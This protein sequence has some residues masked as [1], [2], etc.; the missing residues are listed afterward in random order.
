M[1]KALLTLLLVLLH[2]SAIPNNYSSYSFLHITGDNGLSQSHVK[3]ILKDSYGF[4]W[5]GTKNGLNR[6]DG[7][8]ILQLDC[9]DY[10][11]KKGNHNISALFEDK[12]KKLWVG[13]DRG[14][15]LYD[16]MLD[17]FTA[18]DDKAE[19]GASLDNWVSNIVADSVGNIWVVIPDQGVF[20]YAG[21]KLYFY[22][23]IDRNNFK[24]ETPD[25]IHVTSK[26][27]V[28]VGTWGAGLFRYDTAKDKFEQYKADKDNNS[29]TALSI[30]SICE[31]DGWLIMAIQNGRIMKYHPRQNILRSLDLA[32]VSHTFVRNVSMHGDE[33]WAGTHE[34][35]YIINEK[36]GTVVHLKS[37]LIEP[38]SL[39]DNIIYTMYEDDEGGMWLGTMFGGV[40]Y[41][42]NRGLIFEKY[43][44]LNTGQ[45]LSSKRI[46]ELVEDKKGN[47]WI[48]TE[49]GGVN[50]L[51]RSGQITRM[52]SNDKE[53]RN[54]TI[55]NM[56]IY[57]EN[58]YCGLFKEGLDVIKPTGE[59]V[60]YSDKALNIEEGS[61]WAFC[62]DKKG[63]KWIGTG[64]GLFM[65]D[66]DSFLF[67]KVNEVG[68]DWIFDIFEDREGNL[69]FA[70]MGS[71][72]WKHN[73]QANSFEKYINKEGEP[74]SLSSN[75]VSSVMQDSKGR[76]WLS[77]DRGG[78][79]RYNAETNDFT[80]FSIKEG[81]PDDVAY[82]ILEDDAHNLWFGTNKGLVKFNPETK[83]IHVFTTKDG[84]LGNQFNYKSALKVGDGR[85]FFGGINGLIAFDPN[86]S[87]QQLAPP[88]PIYISK[89]SIYNKEIT[90]HTP[91]SP[92]KKNIVGTEEI[93]LPYNQSNIS[94]DIALLSYST[95]KS[96]QY[97]YRLDPL[98]KDW[99]KAISNQNI[100]YA[101]LSPGKY[102]F[103][104][105]ADNSN[106]QLAKRSLSIVILP[107]WWLS[108]WAYSCYVF[109][110]ISSIWACFF[111]YKRRKE[112]QMTESQKLFEIQKEKELYESKVEFFT[113]IAH[114]IRTPLTLI[115]SPLENV[116]SS[117]SVSD[118]IRDDLEIMD[119]NTNR[120]LDLVNQLL[121]FRKT[122]TQ[123]FQLNFVECDVSDILQ[124]T[125]KRFRL[126]A[127][128][129]ELEFVI[130][131]PETVYASVD[132]E[133]L[134]K[135]ISNLLSNAIKY[136]ETYIRVRLYVEEDKLLFS[137]CNDGPVVP[138]KMREE[139]FKPFIQYK[140][141]VLSSVS[142]TGIG[143]ALARLL[144]ELHEG[145]L[146]MEDSMECNCFLLSL[147]LKHV[148]TVTIE[149]KEPVMNEESSGEGEPETGRKQC[150][151]TLLVVEDSLEMRL[152]V[153]KQLSSEY[154][155]LT[156]VN[157]IEALKVL[158]EHTVNLVISDIMMPEMDGLELCEHLK[159]ELDYSHI[160]IILLTAKTTLQAKIEGMRL[161]ADVYIEKP[162]SVEYL[163]VC[164]SNL[165]SNREKLRVSFAH[166]P[167]VQ[168]NSMA[169][170]KADETFLKT[171]KEVVVANM[172]N[173]EFCLD[174]MA[175]LL[176]MSRSSLN[177]KIKGIL[178]L[179]PN[180][181]IRLERL[182]KAAQ[183]LQEGECKINEV[184]Y[185]TGFNTPSYF[186]KCFQ[187]QFGVLPK[188]FIK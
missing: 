9:D 79:C 114:E 26:G 118:E 119:L 40:N 32:D 142:G 47:V 39:S 53:Q 43:V 127:R 107:P 31:S 126:S 90:V 6:Y 4:M 74:N 140:E 33:I 83:D 46:R 159:S 11:A 137:V 52:K 88:S 178:D 164:V 141:G 3:A 155:V 101:K 29:L 95:T 58:I 96:N 1:K 20:R 30:N 67:S 170:T 81:L 64:S 177:R 109:F 56:S 35:V 36:K 173:P 62:I 8:S 34:G 75:S 117:K 116:L 156:A 110:F 179:T 70:S 186:T 99:V 136:S 149:R 84:L 133:G 54:R 24:K 61:V 169:M 80:S 153:T 187:K 59:V 108:V 87:R 55:L 97:Y 161:G 98:D 130:D 129:K 38:F 145:A 104:I 106:S 168:A 100:S 41:L 172:Q 132:K 128:Q 121:D 13:T 115:K 42:P 112:R 10:V 185:M 50:I 71:G 151:Y 182:K 23:I 122:E 146:Y 163:R 180:D 63:C 113:E 49:D 184:C 68:Y 37:N 82:E 19:S 77:T 176:N 143:L 131:S 15:Y 12:D 124:K 69:W 76:I 144:A 72:V 160:P 138:A 148:Q 147:P 120:L 86:I 171:L 111:W 22:E 167:F 103:R 165:L 48:G 25:C 14:V 18:L 85:F 174:D 154:Q 57:G 27:E 150:R 7:T 66:K 158:G 89:F 93:V 183:L 188:D 134:T 16:M 123:G 166:S 162:F 94:F 135:I 45:S 105:Q 125:C 44:P 2:L 181:Y 28:W 92:L 17:T 157:G 73:P 139:I 102:V 60:H 65:A 51:S 175:S 21:K 5:F 152:F 91:N 78:I